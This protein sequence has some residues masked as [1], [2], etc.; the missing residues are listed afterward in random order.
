MADD[1]DK[2]EAEGGG[3]ES[4]DCLRI[5]YEIICRRFVFA[6]RCRGATSKRS[7]QPARPDPD[8]LKADLKR[9][10]GPHSLM[11]DLV[12]V[13]GWARNIPKYNIPKLGGSN[14]SPDQSLQDDTPSK[15][16]R[17]NFLMAKLLQGL[18]TSRYY[19]QSCIKS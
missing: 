13:A 11:M 18:D 5:L 14:S 10:A 12:P 3:D 2:T 15:I 9:L 1:G 16:Q 8:P 19:L 17:A 7:S 4:E 6:P